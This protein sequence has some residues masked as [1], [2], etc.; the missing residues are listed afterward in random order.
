MNPSTPL[1]A[2]VVALASQPSTWIAAA[3]TLPVAVACALVGTLLMSWKTV[4]GV[5]D[6][7]E[8]PTTIA[9]MTC[10]IG[11][12][13]SLAVD[14]GLRRQGWWP[15]PARNVAAV[16]FIL[17]A[18]GTLYAI[19]DHPEARLFPY[20]YWQI[21]AILMALYF[22]LRPPKD[23]PE[24][25]AQ[26]IG[27]YAG[28]RVLVSAA[29]GWGLA[30]LLAG[31]VTVALFACEELLG[32][33]VAG[34]AVEQVWILAYGIVWPMAFLVG[35]LQALPEEDHE[36]APVPERTPRWIAVLVGW[37]LIPLALL[38]LAILYIYLIQWVLGFG[39]EWG[40]V[41]VLNAA[42]LAFGV[43]AHIAA[44]PLAM[45]GNV[46]ARFYRRVFPWTIPL[47][48]LALGWAV[49]VRLFAYGVTEARGLLVIAVVWLVLLSVA[50]L[51]RG[52]K[53]GPATP[54]GL[55]GILLVLGGH[56]PWG[57][58]ELSFLSQERALRSLLAEHG[59]LEDGR[60]VPADEA[61]PTED[62]ARM[63]HLLAYFNDR[64]ANYRIAELFPNGAITAAERIEALELTVTSPSVRTRT[65][66]VTS[67]EDDR[68]LDVADF[69]LVV[70]VHLM[71]GRDPVTALS[72]GISA[73]LEGTTL[74]LALPDAATPLA[75]DLAPVVAAALEDAGELGDDDYRT[76]ELPRAA[77]TVEAAADPESD[78]G[79]WRARLI[80]ESLPLAH[81]G[82]PESLAPRW[83]EGALLLARP[84]E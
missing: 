20:L 8:L 11:F 49:W 4:G 40:S 67:L 2:I 71:P 78:G 37:A 28:A 19:P 47:P 39:T 31:G 72:G 55:L 7:L 42:Y 33:T 13:S 52:A 38:Y 9:L 24:E 62:Q 69:D 12:F 5:P 27:W 35:T 21:G 51:L 76:V 15:R 44:M 23:A 26:L 66:Q 3:R 10:G 63:V 68:A 65:L 34:G 17:V 73:R 30:T 80:V 22:A 46:L 50:W 75:L 64:G 56:G 77:R 43:A 81:D 59:M 83:L 82:A 58:P 1:A 48:L 29:M 16:V 25:K 32:L 79:G 14:W 60:A 61:V 57:A 53:A 18:G 74:S 84:A 6:V 54:V 36:R 45:Q 41:A 70:P